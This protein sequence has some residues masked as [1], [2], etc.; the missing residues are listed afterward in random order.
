METTKDRYISNKSANTKWFA[1]PI[2]RIAREEFYSYEQ[3]KTIYEYY[4]EVPT[5]G[6]EKVVCDKCL[7]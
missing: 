6:K 5:Y 1:C 3:H 7:D 4:P 2:C